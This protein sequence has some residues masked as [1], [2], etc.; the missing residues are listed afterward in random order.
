MWDFPELNFPIG[1]WV[2]WLV[3]WLTQHLAAFFDVITTAIREPLV[4]IKNDV[5]LW[6]PWW[7]VIILVAAIAWRIA[8]WKVALLSV[9]GLFF[10]GAMGR[11]DDTMTTVA[12]M[13]TSVIVSVMIGVPLGIISAKSDRFEALQRPILDMMQTMPAFVYLVPAVFFFGLGLVPAVVA[14][15]IYAIPPAIRL[16][17]LGIRQVSPEVVEAGRSFGTT[18]WQ[19]LLKIQLPLA[20]PNIMAGVNQT[21]MMALAMVVLCSMI[22]AAGLGLEVL[23]GMNNLDVGRG[24][25]AGISI[26]IVAIILD[27]ITAALGKKG[28]TA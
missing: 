8:N 19:L 26:V 24:F 23:R 17:N 15:C 12:I 9:I 1:E 25:E 14:T 28:R 22:G 7:V 11:W 10:I 3:D 2:N 18:P 13:V 5:L 4:W 16:T 27:R 6:L 20:L 21:I